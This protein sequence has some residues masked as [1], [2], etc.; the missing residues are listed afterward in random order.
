MPDKFAAVTFAKQETLF[1]CGPATAKMVLS[2][3]GVASPATPP[4]WQS[5]LWD[6]IKSNTG[7]TRPSSAPNEPTA[8]PF[9]TQKCEWC[10][11]WKCWSTTPAVLVKLLN[12]SQGVATY[13]ISTH[14]IE[15]AATGV[16]LDTIDQTLPGVALVYGWNHW[17]VVE[18]YRQGEAGSHAVAG[19]NLN[20]VY[21]RDPEASTAVHYVDWIEWRDT[22]LSFV[23]CGMF[24]NTMVVAGGTRLA[25]PPIDRPQ[26]PT[27]VRIVS[28]PP[29]DPLAMIKHILTPEQ[30]MQRAAQQLTELR[31]SRLRVALDS[32]EAKLAYLVQRLDDP[33]L[34]YYIVTFQ[35]S[36]KETARVVV[37]AF[38]GTLRQASGIEREGD[39][40]K[41]YIPAP[42]AL[43]RLHSYA[44]VAPDALRFRVRTGTV[45]QHPVLVWKPCKQSTSPFLPFYQLSI[46]DSFVYY[47]VDG[48]EFDALTEGPA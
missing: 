41:P 3:L 16:M 21:I 28:V 37:D 8:P 31:S 9:P 29:P 7:A 34:Y 33:D 11:G 47:R 24:K 25:S 20:G 30:A 35:A 45:G 38:N 17:V 18:G 43:A 22:Y 10:S 23:P 32:V 6:Y 40:L 48:E 5:Q 14:T 27:N 26:A 19:R 12:A 42:A 4:S 46:G 15:D 44:E 39:S 1:F 13:A 2:S 36:A